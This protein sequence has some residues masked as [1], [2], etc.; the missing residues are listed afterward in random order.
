MTKLRIRL[1]FCGKTQRYW[2]VAR[3]PCANDPFN[4]D[5]F[6]YDTRHQPAGGV[7]S[8]PDMFSMLRVWQQ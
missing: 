8:I 7:D 2:L 1:H 5:L 4:E 3:R 6:T